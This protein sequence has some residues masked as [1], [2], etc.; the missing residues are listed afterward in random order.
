M[1]LRWA[2]PRAMRDLTVP[3]GTSKMADN[4]FSNIMSSFFVSA[5]SARTGAKLQFSGGLLTAPSGK[6]HSR[7]EAISIA[8]D[9]GIPAAR[10][11]SSE[12]DL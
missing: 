7:S 12:M 4:V 1:C 11:A 5:Q 10:A 8:S 6:I 3:M 2:N 9:G